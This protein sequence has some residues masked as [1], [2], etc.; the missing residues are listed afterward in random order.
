MK[1]RRMRW[2]GHVARTG[3]NSNVNRFLVGKPDGK[4]PL[5]RPRCRWE[6]NIKMDVRE[7]GRHG[8]GWFHLAQDRETRK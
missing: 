4:R 7:I 5:G 2:P 8:I 3:E 1:S 6:D